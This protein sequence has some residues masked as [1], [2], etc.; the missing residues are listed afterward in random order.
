MNKR[1]IAC[2]VTLVVC[3]VSA[4]A[5]AAQTGEKTATQFYME[6]RA[7][8]DKAKAVEDI[9]PFMSASRRKQVES[10][11]AD[12]RKQ[13]F[14]M[15]KMMGALTNIKVTK[16]SRTANGATLSVD[17]LDGDKSKTTGTITLVQEN[18]AWK[19]DK[20][21]FKSSSN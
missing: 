5:L 2:C 8:F 1:A 19:I 6:Y 11:P 4:V 3:V 7:A 21:S 20:E 17:A 18:G 15:I 14:E 12:E 10:T 9:L 13:M 16:E